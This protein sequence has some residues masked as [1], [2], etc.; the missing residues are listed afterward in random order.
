[1]AVEADQ[2]ALMQ[3]MNR[4]LTLQAE[5]LNTITQRLGNQSAAYQDMTDAAGKATEQIRS[6]SE[7]TNFLDE[8]IKGVTEGWENFTKALTNLIPDSVKNGF[9]LLKTNFTSLVSAIVGPQAAVQGFFSTIYD[10]FIKHAAELA[11]ESQRFAEALEEVRDKFGDLNENTSRQVVA[12]ARTLSSG[13]A[14][15]SGSS[16]AFA[17]KFGVGVDASIAKLQKMSEIAGD[18]G[19]TF[20]TLGEEGFKSASTQLYVLKDGLNFTSEGLQAT[21]RLAQ[22]SGESLTSFSQHIMASVNKI[23][24]HFGMSTKVLGGDVGKALGNFKMLGKMTGDYVKEITKAAV[25]TRKLGI[26]ITSLTGLVDKFDDFESGAEAAA[27]L[28]QGF[29]LVVDPLKMMGM[30]VGPRLAELQK[31]FIATGRSIDSMTRQERALLAQTSGLSD[32]QVQLAFSQKGLS[33]SYDDISKGA[34]EAAEKQKSNQEVMFDLAKNIKNLILPL[35]EFTGFIEAFVN[36]FLRG[37]GMSGGFLSILRPLA[38]A[39][40]EVADIGGQT[41]R[42]FADFLFSKKDQNAPGSTL[43]IMQN[44]SD[45]FV[46]IAKHVRE[47]VKALTSGEDVSTTVGNF[48]ESIFGIVDNTFNKSVAG[49]DI[50]GLAIKFGTKIVE[51]FTGA[52]KFFVKQ[53][54]K[55]TQ[56]LKEMFKPGSV[57]GG[58]GGIFGSIFKALGEL[59]DE[60]P[61]LIPVLKDLGGALVDTIVR[62]FKE[63]PIVSAITGLFLA[64]GPVFTIL[65]GV[66]RSAFIAI[67]SAFGFGIKDASKSTPTTGDTVMKGAAEG[68]ASGVLGDTTVAVAEASASWLDK[69]FEVVKDPAKIALMAGGIASAIVTIGGSIHT[70]LMSFM[71]KQPGHDKSFVETVADAARLFRNVDGSDLLSLGLVIGSVFAGVGA[72]VAAVALGASKLGVGGA[73]A[74]LIAG[75]GG[76][77]LFS[78]GS[79]KGMISEA[80]D[81]VGGMVKDIAESFGKADFVANLNIVAGLKDQLSSLGSV[82]ESIEKV[83]KGILAI[84][85]VMPTKWSLNDIG[86][87]ESAIMDAVRLLGG[88]SGTSGDHV[89]IVWLLKT[90]PDMTGLV[91]K[92]AGMSSISNIM[93]SIA[94]V[95]K[96]LE[97]MPD[98]Q[99]ANEKINSLTSNGGNSFIS[100]LNNFIGVQLSQFKDVKMPVGIDTIKT[101]ID[102]ITGIVTALSGLKE[103][104]I[105]NANDSLEKMSEG[106]DGGTS[107]LDNLDS[108]LSSLGVTS[109]NM[110]AETLINELTQKKSVIEAITPLIEALSNTASVTDALIG[111]GLLVAFFPAMNNMMS[112]ASDNLTSMKTLDPGIS[113]NLINDIG[114]MFDVIESYTG[115][116]DGVS[117]YLSV[118]KLAAFETRITALRDHVET[119]RSILANIGEIDLE[120]TINDVKS[121][122]KVAKS[123]MKINGGAVNISVNMTVNMNA[124]KMAAALVMGG[125]IDPQPDFGTFLMNNDGVEDKFE[126]STNAARTYSY[127]G[128]D[129]TG[130]QRT[131]S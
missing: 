47:F 107:F 56:G 13:L 45:M 77:A 65:A 98:V 14:D 78:V 50:G 54:P 102:S 87:M 125:Y 7:S 92:D 38:T 105:K 16:K 122:M 58:T 25:F 76:K 62:F 41:G 39:L 111:T 85:D 113:A 89:G 88:S 3:E 66:A 118:E 18:L 126:N 17:G 31:G 33:M 26:E 55:W 100:N 74:V 6:Q 19:P 10:F 30:E 124:E 68:I 130:T 117:E 12:S 83:I 63:Y 43:S 119:V 121:G 4:L 15:A 48:L 59:T 60:L 82:G 116:V 91:G 109:F 106:K 34:N 90:L 67:K 81:A 32:E 9:N 46:N 75:I 104:S 2:I 37:F 110:G 131:W 123:V 57:G 52:I 127:G 5:S 120:G 112:V 70:V 114:Y 49:F 72:V 79:E 42:I 35:V 21:T 84:Q 69:L 23:G 51:V 115:R 28:A 128:S 86:K 73:L 61:K 11:K 99:D 22:V 27:Q 94:S 24:K 40:K 103:G 80:L 129:N 108:V 53:I 29:G 95:I 36:G 93:T 1:M 8:C 44:I 64:G 20:D 97:E 96:S 101:A 71:E